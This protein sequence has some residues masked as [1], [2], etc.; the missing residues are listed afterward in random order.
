VGSI[1]YNRTMTHRGGFVLAAVSFALLDAG[2]G[3]VTVNAD[4]GSTADAAEVVDTGPS[5]DAPPGDPCAGNP[6]LGEFVSCLTD[7]I[8]DLF[9][10]CDCFFAN[11][12]T[13]E[14]ARFE[15][16]GDVEAPYL[17]A[18][19][20]D[21]VQAGILTYDAVQAGQCLSFL[22]AP[23][24][25]VLHDESD[26]FRTTCR[27][28]TGTV[29]SAGVCFTEMECATP[30]SRCDQGPCDGA[31]CCAGSCTPPAAINGDCTAEGL[32]PPDAHCVQGATARTCL[33]GEA[34]SVCN[35]DGDCDRDHHCTGNQCRPDLDTDELC[36]RDAQCQAPDR[37]VGN[38]LGIGQGSCRAVDTVNAACEDECLGCL[39][40][41]RPDPNQLGTCAARKPIDASCGD[42]Q[43]CAGTVETQCDPTS[44]TCRPRGVPDGQPCSSSNIC[45][46]GSFCTNE[47]SGGPSGTCATPQPN[48]SV[49]GGDDQCASGI[50]AGTPT[51]TCVAF[52]DCR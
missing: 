45:L 12:S 22:R 51:Q 44:T 21:A 37:C 26:L 29:Q 33:T 5:V 20:A 39:Y 14:A 34:G 15:L 23:N 25:S 3:K 4:A 31:A 10:R 35:S 52:A 17:D 48:G 40:C 11:A 18:Y 32:C 38:S 36:V 46:F 8:C 41:D 7:A 9:D 1:R 30:G 43:E 47:I 49:C 19:L 24:C 6:A 16:Y 28:F 50:C 42:N 2:C 13:C 27:P